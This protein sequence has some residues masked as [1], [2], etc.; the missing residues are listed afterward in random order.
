MI[1]G[2]QAT[3]RIDRCLQG[4]PCTLTR[5]W[6]FLVNRKR[7]GEHRSR[8]ALV[9]ACMHKTLGFIPQSHKKPKTFLPGVL[10]SMLILEESKPT[11]CMIM[12]DSH[13]LILV[14]FCL[15]HISSEIKSNSAVQ[16]GLELIM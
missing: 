11:L 10:E 2:K 13:R 5:F 4:F 16:G 8:K 14:A 3:R 1:Q 7:F 9:Q 12:L 6:P 15:E